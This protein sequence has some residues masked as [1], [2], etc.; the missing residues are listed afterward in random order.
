V[1]IYDNSFLGNNGAIVTI[2][3][4]CWSIQ[5]IQNFVALYSKVLQTIGKVYYKNTKLRSIIFKSVYKPLVGSI[6]KR[7]KTL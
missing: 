4:F 5:K 3:E 6:T 1:D 7:Y 2:K